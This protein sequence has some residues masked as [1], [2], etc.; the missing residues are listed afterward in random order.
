MKYQPQ[1]S[2]TVILRVAQNEGRLQNFSLKQ[3]PEAEM[4]R[5]WWLYNRT[6]GGYDSPRLM[7]EPPDMLLVKTIVAVVTVMLSLDF[8]FIYAGL[9]V[10]CL[11]LL[12]IH[13]HS[14]RKEAHQA[15]QAYRWQMRKMILS[16][17]KPW[18]KEDTYEED[19]YE[20]E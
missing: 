1:E 15:I 3:I 13:T 4:D 14:K 5:A 6:N 11:A 20:E 7:D 10:S 8:Q 2:P 16:T 17:Q 18:K 19:T 9:S 12:C